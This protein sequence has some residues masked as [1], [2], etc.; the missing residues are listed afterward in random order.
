MS[1]IVNRLMEIKRIPVLGIVG[2]AGDGETQTWSW[3]SGTAGS[4]HPH[5]QGA[6]EVGG[7]VGRSPEPVGSVPPLGVSGRTALNCGTVSW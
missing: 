1:F 3:L 7:L 6:P 4:L 2:A 5:V